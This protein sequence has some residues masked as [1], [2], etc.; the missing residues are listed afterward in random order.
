MSIEAEQEQVEAVVCFPFFPLFLIVSII[1]CAIFRR[2]RW[3]APFWVFAVC[4]V[5]VLIRLLLHLLV[6]TSGGSGSDWGWVVMATGFILPLSLWEVIPGIILL[7]VYPRRSAWGVHAILPCIL[8]A[9]LS[10]VGSILAIQ[11]LP[12]PH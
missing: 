10:L 11:Y 2:S 12:K 9:I 5:V 8:A 6:R 3:V 4:F 7:F 1:V